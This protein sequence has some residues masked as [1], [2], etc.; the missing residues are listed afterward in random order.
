MSKGDYV[1]YERASREEDR[2]FL[3]TAKE[4]VSEIKEPRNWKKPRDPNK[5]AGGKKV[6]YDFKTMLLVLLLMVYHRKEYREMESHL[7]NN[8]HLLKELGLEKSPGKSTIQRAAA[9]ISLNTLV[10]LNDVVVER[11]KK[12]AVLLQRRT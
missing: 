6:A 9:K 8:P 7:N 10:R 11:F 12:S 4:V 5:H 1:V 2:L 3:E